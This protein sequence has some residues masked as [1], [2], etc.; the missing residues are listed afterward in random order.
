[1]P[2][3]VEAGGKG[4]FKKKLLRSRL[5]WAGHMERMGDEKLTKRLDAEKVDGKRRRGRPRMGWEGCV[6]RDVGKVR[7]IQ[8]RT[9]A[10]DRSWRLL[11]ENVV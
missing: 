5:K 1:M 2:L 6:M 8:H 10:K 7:R 11:M 4:S 9:T 3:R